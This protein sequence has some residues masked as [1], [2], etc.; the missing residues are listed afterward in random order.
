MWQRALARILAGVLLTVSATGCAR[1]QQRP[2]SVQL[3]SRELSSLVAQAA[4]MDSGAGDTAAV[5]IGNRA[6]VAIRLNDPQPG[7]TNGASLL[8]S[9]KEADRRDMTDAGTGPTDLHGPGGSTGI[10]PATPGGGL[11]PGGWT[12]GGGSPVRTQ[13]ISNGAGGLATESGTNGLVPAPGGLGLAP[14]DVMSRVSNQIRSRIPQ[15]IEVRFAHHPS[16]ALQLL[17]LAQRL[18]GGESAE[19]LAA[20]FESLYARAVPAGVTEFDPMTPQPAHDG[21]LPSDGGR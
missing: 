16:D 17:A 19:S 7:G 4:T 18:E 6:L 9:T 3:S 21:T 1:P 12:P 13:A 5:V 2:G 10:N 11:H 20:D 15:V 14:L 8:G